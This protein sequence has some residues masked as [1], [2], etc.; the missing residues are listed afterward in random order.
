MTMPIAF[1]NL[2][3]LSNLNTIYRVGIERTCFVK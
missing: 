3:N 2:Q 1:K